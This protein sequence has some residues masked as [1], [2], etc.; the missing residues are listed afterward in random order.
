MINTVI[1]NN[2]KQKLSLDNILSDVYL[3]PKWEMIKSFSLM[4]KKFFIKTR[5]INVNLFR[6]FSSKNLL[7]KYSIRTT[8]GN[9]LANMTLKVYKD[10][11]YIIDLD[12]ESNMNFVQI[13]EK[14]LQVSIEKALYNTTGKEVF[15]NLTSGLLTKNRIKKILLSNDF[16][17]E[18][19][20]SSYEKDMFGETFS[21]KT[22]NNILWGK[23]IKQ[24][25]ILINK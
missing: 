11:V 4:Q 15:I 6:K 21:I 19:N 14:L 2:N 7:E 23:R 8:D 22:D 5:T 3:L 12:I 10:C 13:T 9:N 1:N 18:E 16:I 24:S 17:Q 25:P 20:Q